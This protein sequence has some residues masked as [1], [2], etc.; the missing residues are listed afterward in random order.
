MIAEIIF[1]LSATLLAVAIVLTFVRIV[2]GPSLAD[3]VVGFDMLAASAIGLIT[4]AAIQYDEPLFIDV[5][6]ILALMAFL[7]T[8]AF[9]HYLERKEGAE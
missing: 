7:S 8:V 9:A 1:G 4:I 2:R 3:R 5:A 6:L